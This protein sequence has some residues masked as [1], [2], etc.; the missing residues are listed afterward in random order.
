MKRKQQFCLCDSSTSSLPTAGWKAPLNQETD[1]WR[2]ERTTPEGVLLIT[3]HNPLWISHYTPKSQYREADDWMWLLRPFDGVGYAPVL[4]FLLSE[5]L[6]EFPWWSALCPES[7]GFPPFFV[8]MSCLADRRNGNAPNHAG[9][10]NNV[11]HRCYV[12]LSPCIDSKR[13]LP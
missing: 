11:N 7:L 1:E 3:H 2:D 12:A 9:D 13:T 6:C 10:W 4:I 5:W 8:W